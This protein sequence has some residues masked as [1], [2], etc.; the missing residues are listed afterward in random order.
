MVETVMPNWR[1][2]GK[3][4]LALWSRERLAADAGLPSQGSGFPGFALAHNVR[5]AAEVD[6]LLAHVAT[7]RRRSV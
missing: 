5:S 4:W 6:A 2:R 7:R 1:D 3:T